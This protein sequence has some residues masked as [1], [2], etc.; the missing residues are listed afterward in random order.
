MRGFIQI[1]EVTFAAALLLLT[2]PIFFGGLNVKHVW[3]KQDLQDTS[4]K[5]ISGLVLS[6]NISKLLNETDLVLAHIEAVKPVNLLFAIKVSGTPK[7]NITLGCICGDNDLAYIRQ[8]LTPAYLNNRNITFTIFKTDIDSLSQSDSVIFVNYADWGAQKA[9]I[10]DYLKAGGKIIAFQDGASTQAFLDVFNLTTASDS[11]STLKFSQNHTIKNYFQ[12]FGFDVTTP[13]TISEGQPPV[14]KKRGFWRIWEAGREVKVSDSLV[15]EIQNTPPIAVTEGVPFTLTG[16]DS[17]PYTFKVKKVFSDKSSVI[18]QPVSR[19]LA[20]Q[21]FTRDSG[22]QRVR[23]NGVIDRP[24]SFQA[25]AVNNTAVWMSFTPSA[26]LSDEYRALLKASVAFLNSEF[27]V[28]EPKRPAPTT[29][30]SSAFYTLCCDM[31]ENIEVN[32]IS[33]FAY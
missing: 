8:I 30:S 26:T 33:W 29:A 31:P 13:D 16:P 5:I 18:I 11:T 32:L 24:G 17:Q 12:G 10:D 2:I 21:D 9:K 25:L 28:V 3:E 15:V 23:G 1:I 6:G 19:N 4:N 7:T 27:F 22:E 14:N 20:F